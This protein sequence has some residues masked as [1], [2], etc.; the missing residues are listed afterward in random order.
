MKLKQ[1]VS[2]Q[3]LILLLA[4]IVIVFMI[5]VAK[6]QDFN[7]LMINPHKRTLAL[8]SAPQM[9][10]QTSGA[11]SQNLSNG[12]QQVLQIKMPQKSLTRRLLDNTSLTYYHQFLGPTAAGSINETY[13]VF[14]EGMNVERSGRA[15]LQSFHA[16]NLRYQINPKWAIGAS[17][18][19]V[20]GYT[21]EVENRGG[22]VNR[23]GDEFFNARAYVSL[24]ALAF[25]F[26]TLYSTVSYEAPTSVISRNDGM[27]GGLVISESLSFN[28]PNRKWN[29]GILGQ[30]Y[31]AY[32]NQDRNVK[33]PPF[34]GGTPT[35]LQTVIVSGGPYVNYRFNDNWQLGSVFTFDWDQ[36]GV[37]TD[38]REFNN[39]LPHRGRTT[40]SYFPK[41]LK[42][43]SN[44]GVFSQAL[45][46]FRPETTAFGA[47]VALRF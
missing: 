11:G 37:Q 4:A 42:F 14:Q 7:E 33:P 8:N 3:L 45:L 40:L 35:Q 20:N 2:S 5:Q 10:N 19:A 44:M 31:R 46:K 6:A 16:A 30:Y 17:L 32:F 23:P 12:S 21:R 41:N 9:Q 29:V 38:S 43:V 15:P 25:S 1:T 13:N 34:P 22:G 24:P 27:T 26:G 36:R 28:M 18:A 39:N 47:E